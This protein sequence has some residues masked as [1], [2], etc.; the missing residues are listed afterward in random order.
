MSKLKVK[1]MKE[2]NNKQVVV[3][4]K[5][6]QTQSKQ[7]QKNGG[8]TKVN[9]V[10]KV[11]SDKN[12]NR[13]DTK[14]VNETQSGTGKENRVIKSDAKKKVTIKDYQ[15][16]KL[17]QNRNEQILENIMHEMTNTYDNIIT[18]PPVQDAQTPNYIETMQAVASITHETVDET[19]DKAV[20]VISECALD[21]IDKLITQEV[22]GSVLEQ[23]VNTYI[24]EKA[25][26]DTKEMNDET[27]QRRMADKRKCSAT[28]ENTEGIKRRL[29]D[30]IETDDNENE[31]EQDKD[32]RF[33]AKI[34]AN[35]VI[36]NIGGARFETSILTLQKDSESL[37]AK[38][39]TSDSPITPQGNS[40]FIDRDSSHFKVILNYLRCDLDLKPATLPKKRRHLIEL[41]KECYYYRVKGL[42]KM[43]K[44]RL[45]LTTELYDMD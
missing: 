43:V 45:K 27:T 4:T 44:R 24:N 25:Q 7:T 40:V 12:S 32:L 14:S 39:F 31:I 36:L 13:N 16:R 8:E 10:K 29:Y 21:F 19:Y 9:K 38:L 34:Q 20:D 33:I 42:R 5:E 22:V 23:G 1:E 3:D 18:L 2:M 17:E 28:D 41:K 35:K 15:A 6:K 37:L 11:L 30:Y 26:K